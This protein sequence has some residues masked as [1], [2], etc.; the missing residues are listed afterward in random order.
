[1]LAIVDELVKPSFDLS[2]LFSIVFSAVL[3]A[4]G[5]YLGAYIKRKGEDLANQE[6]FDNL[7]EHLRKTTQDTEEI[8]NV[9]LRKH[10]LRQ[11]QWAIREQHYMNL[12]SHLMKLKISLQDR[13]AYYLR[14]G[15]E[16]DENL[17]KSESFQRLAQ[18]GYESYQSIRELIGPASVFL[19]PKAIQSLEQLVR[20]H[21][22]IQEFSV[23]T[24]EYILDA[25]KLVD[26]A[27]LLILTEARSELDYSVL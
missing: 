19:S 9:L 24:A 10:W 12:L 20:E 8:K 26:D 11:Q 18:V 17:S 15:S 3:C 1:M 21:W 7:R 6:N 16:H 5:A 2:T 13:D 25:L 14:P 27:Q 23:C 4:I 22:Q